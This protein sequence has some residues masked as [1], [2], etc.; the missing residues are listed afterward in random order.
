MEALTIDQQELVEMLL[1]EVGPLRIRN[2]PLAPT[3]RQ[4]AFLRLTAREVLFG[5]A[6]AGGKSLA[7]LM[8][9]LMYSDVPGYHALLLRPT[10]AEFEL[11][12]GL[13][14]LAQQWLAPS[15][16]VWHGDTRTWRFPGPG[17][18]GA[19]GASLVFGY[20]DR[21][22]DSHRYAGS[23]FSYVG[24]DE[25]TRFD[26][27]S[28]RRMARVLR[29]ADQ[30]DNLP[31]APDGTTLADVPVRI[32]ATSNPGGAGHGWV[33]NY[34][35][36]PATRPDGVLFL[37]S[38]L[39][40]NPH[41]DR[42]AYVDALNVLSGAERARL[43]EGDWEIPDDGELFQRDWFEQIA[44]NQLPETVAKVRYWD[45][46]ATEPGPGNPD[47]DYT[48]GLKLERDR[49]GTFYVTNI[50]RERRT[51]AAV[52][53]LV[54]AT[55]ISD[56]QAVEIRIEQEGGS[57]GK[58]LIDS[59]KREILRG[60]RVRSIKP[61][62]NK[63]VRALV[64]ASAA[65]NQLIKLLP[66]RHTAAFLDELAAFPNGPHDDLVDALAG[67]HEA[68]HRNIRTARWSFTTETYDQIADRVHAK[69]GKPCRQSA[70]IAQARLDRDRAATERLAGQLGMSYYDSQRGSF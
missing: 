7:Q 47:P 35:V 60:Y 52:A 54:R 6:V 65:E 67:A 57:A 62:T 26:E 48:V 32:R 2:C 33:K 41:I 49:H 9:A 29:Q 10:L 68:L 5:G 64:V 36:D 53:D 34:F 44:R 17:K 70:A 61:T 21:V 45:M 58:A 46:A 56:G 37:P 15:K 13:L 63:Q 14:D 18:S 25:L 42:D 66:S 59:Y 8:A 12:G 55:A 16:A 31:A 22:P 40:D 39:Q 27:T 20:L 4:E 3:P 69:E 51:P 11:P 1:D 23:S 30:A 24:F 50:V 38:R 19:G 43:L 28:Y